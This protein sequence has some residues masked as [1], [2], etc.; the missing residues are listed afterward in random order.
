MASAAD[1]RTP[2]SESF[3]NP[4]RERYTS[5]STAVTTSGFRL[6]TAIREDRKKPRHAGTVTMGVDLH[7][8]INRL[9]ANLRLRVAHENHHRGHA[10]EIAQ[11]CDRA[12]H[13]QPDV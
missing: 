8:A 9:G 11:G 12:Q 4:A 5:K 6:V 2:E 10:R 3:N 7:H 1:S 13:G